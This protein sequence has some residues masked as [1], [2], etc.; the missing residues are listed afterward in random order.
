MKESFLRMTQ[1]KIYY[2]LEHILLSKEV[3]EQHFGFVPA[4]QLRKT[5]ASKQ[6]EGT[7]EVEV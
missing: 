2:D 3:Y 7:I 6:E 1:I 4:S 5:R